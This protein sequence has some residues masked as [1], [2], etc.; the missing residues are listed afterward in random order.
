MCVSTHI[1]L[2]VSQSTCRKKQ[3]LEMQGEA[4]N[5]RNK[6]NSGITGL[7]NVHRFLSFALDCKEVKP[8]NPIGNQS[9]IITGR[10]NAQAEVPIL[11]P[12]D[13]KNW[14]IGKDRDAGKD[15]RQED[16]G[17]TED[18]IVGWY[19]RLG[20]H[21]FEQTPGVGDGQ[22]SL[23]CCSPRGRK[24]SDTTE[25]LNWYFSTLSTTRTARWPGSLLSLL[26]TWSLSA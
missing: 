12:P 23:V 8:V 26:L 19:H 2:W 20:G 6:Q 18:E 17:M 22:G 15:W 21:E 10:T 3:G 1:Q 13:A 11:R 9:W 25:R 4:N 16:R 24:E 5:I 7:D 14:L